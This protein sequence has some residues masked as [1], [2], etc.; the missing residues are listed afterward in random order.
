MPNT[1]H[2]T[3]KLSVIPLIEIHNATFAKHYRDGLCWSLSGDYRGDKPFSDAHLV[4]NL[5]RD[6]ARG[7]F[8]GQHEEYLLYVGFYFGTLYGCLLLPQTGQLR[9]DATTLTTFTHPDAA[10][11]YYVGAV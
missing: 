10:K 3:N 4:A 7:Y 6:A 11:G 9:S 1:L 5:K 2:I 8:D